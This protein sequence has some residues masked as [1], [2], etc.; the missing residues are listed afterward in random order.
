MADCFPNYS[1]GNR[2]QFQVG[3]AD[4]YISNKI[5]V[6]LVELPSVD[7]TSFVINVPNII[8]DSFE[9]W[10]DG[11]LAPRDVTTVPESYGVVY[12]ADKIT[13]NFFPAY[14]QDQIIVVRF[15]YTS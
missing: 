6:N 14:R 1:P 12:E 9:L 2:I 4:S 15:E 7:D 13:V 8:D 5:D 3:V 10:N 11:S